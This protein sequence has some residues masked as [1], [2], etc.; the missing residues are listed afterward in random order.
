MEELYEKSQQVLDRSA[1]QRLARRV[2]A[3]SYVECSALSQEGLEEVFNKVG[4][5]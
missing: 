2:G 3:V 1:G 5:Y 4:I